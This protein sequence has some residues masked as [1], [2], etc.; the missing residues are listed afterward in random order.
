MAD[1]DIV[2]SSQCK[3]CFGPVK[4]A[5]ACYL[6]LLPDELLLCIISYLEVVRGFLPDPEAESVRQE[7]NAR[8]VRA[9]YSMTLTCRKLHAITT[10]FLYTSFIQT[11]K[12]LDATKLF[13]TTLCRQPTLAKH[14]KYLEILTTSMSSS[15]LPV[16]CSTSEWGTVARWLAAASW[17]I[18]NMRALF[19]RNKSLPWY[20]WS[21]EENETLPAALWEAFGRSQG[22]GSL[23]LPI[24]L[25][26][27]LVDNL[28]EVAI[29]HD[30]FLSSALAFRRFSSS[31]GLRCLWLMS[32]PSQHDAMITIKAQPTAHHSPLQDYIREICT[33]V[34]IREILYEHPSLSQNQLNWNAA[35]EELSF[36]IYDMESRFI[37]GH[38]ERC[39]A[40]TRVSINWISHSTKSASY[41]YSESAQPI[42][43][44][45]PNKP[46]ELAV[47]GQALRKF[48]STLQSL[49]VDTLDSGWLVDMETDIPALGSLRDFT[50]LANLE[51]SGLALWGDYNSLEGPD[52]RLSSLL[53]SSIASLSIRT[54]WDDDVE[55]ALHMLLP[56]CTELLP[57]L[58]RVDCSWRP[59]PTAI[60]DY[61]VLA[62]QEQGVD[63][64]LDAEED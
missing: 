32:R 56:D 17:N 59:A 31:A 12:H 61:L 46:I 44:K 40:L 55:H 9:L 33:S 39:N 49:R 25:I 21:F 7:H 8:T 30:I 53:P 64:I 52:E 27:A 34:K 51:V 11:Q 43:I 36:D 47:I 38:L 54:E 37:C 62:F 3:P 28:G 4:D 57:N 5:D 1:A 50:R 48:T 14:V 18:P 13:Q 20:A 45:P 10:P 26:I 35:L 16:S 6:S 15:E 58:K 41:S 63:L 24:I 19:Q 42:D 2:I 29:C 22:E 23:I 60:A